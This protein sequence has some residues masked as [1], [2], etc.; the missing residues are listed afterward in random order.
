MPVVTKLNGRD[1]S[2]RIMLKRQPC[3]AAGGVEERACAL[4]HN[5]C[6]VA[7]RILDEDLVSLSL[8]RRCKHIARVMVLADVGIENSRRQLQCGWMQRHGEMFGEGR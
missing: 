4:R 1:P 5:L 3:G 7:L 6:N 8:D 2:L